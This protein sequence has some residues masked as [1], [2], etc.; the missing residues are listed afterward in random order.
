MPWENCAILHHFI[1]NFKRYQLS[2]EFIEKYINDD[3]V[4]V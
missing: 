2:E 1:I 3:K 4:K